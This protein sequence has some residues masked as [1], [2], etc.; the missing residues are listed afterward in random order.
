MV[1]KAED[2]FDLSTRNFKAFGSAEDPERLHINSFKKIM[3]RLKYFPSPWD[4]HVFFIMTNIKLTHF[5]QT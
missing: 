2:V 5:L 1:S 3:F 4:P